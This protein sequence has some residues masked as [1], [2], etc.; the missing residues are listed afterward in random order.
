MRNELRVNGRGTAK[1]GKILKRAALVLAIAGVA[2]TFCGC[3]SVHV[4]KDE[5]QP[6]PVIVVPQDHP[7]P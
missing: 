7:N 2:S 5:E 4:H 3:L 1:A 6:S